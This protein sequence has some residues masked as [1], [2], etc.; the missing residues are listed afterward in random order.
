MTELSL[1]QIDRKTRELN[2]E[3]SFLFDNFTDRVIAA[4]TL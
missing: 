2:Q 4:G 3:S 1:N